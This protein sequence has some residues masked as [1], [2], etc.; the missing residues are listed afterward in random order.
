[1]EVFVRY[2]AGILDMTLRVNEKSGVI[3]MTFTRKINEKARKLNMTSGICE[4]TE[5]VLKNYRIL[6]KT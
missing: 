2:A 5:T 3:K 1:M 4:K 6:D